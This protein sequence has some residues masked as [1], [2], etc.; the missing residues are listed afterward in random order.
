[1]GEDTDYVLLVNVPQY[2]ETKFKTKPGS[3]LQLRFPGLVNSKD[4]PVFMATSERA[5][6]LIGTSAPQ[7]DTLSETYFVDVLFWADDDMEG[8]QSVSYWY[9]KYSSCTNDLT[10][11]TCQH[12][13]YTVQIGDAKPSNVS[14]TRS[15]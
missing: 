12:G 13:T 6:T 9:S 4:E 11:V 15:P 2:S 7:L 14:S 8:G 5:L 10:P 3:F 1:M